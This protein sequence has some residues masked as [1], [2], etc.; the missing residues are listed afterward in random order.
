MID[1]VVDILRRR[2]KLPEKYRDHSLAGDYHGYRECHIKPD[3]LLIYSTD[4]QC[5]YLARVGSHS[6]LF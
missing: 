3:V 2:K 1:E 5:L 4:Q 6:E